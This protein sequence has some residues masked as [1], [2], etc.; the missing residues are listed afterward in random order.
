MSNE[1]DYF[2]LDEAS[3]DIGHSFGCYETSESATRAFEMGEIELWIDYHR[4]KTM[5]GW[6]E[7]EEG[8]KGMNI[9]ERWEMTRKK[10]PDDSIKN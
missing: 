5:E 7:W 6:T 1:P 2:E 9:P 4:P 8:H 3:Y 10:S